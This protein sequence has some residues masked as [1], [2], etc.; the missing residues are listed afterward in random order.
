MN[1]TVLSPAY[2]GGH[3]RFVVGLVVEALSGIRPALET[4][5]ISALEKLRAVLAGAGIA[6]LSAE[7]VG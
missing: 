1:P 4:L 5:V 2:I 6:V 3:T 7:G